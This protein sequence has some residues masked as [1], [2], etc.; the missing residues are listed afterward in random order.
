MWTTA[1]A[2]ELPCPQRAEV[3]NRLVDTL[4]LQVGL[5]IL[6][7]VD[8]L[9]IGWLINNS[10]DGPNEMM[11]HIL[12]DDSRPTFLTNAYQT[13]VRVGVHL[14]A[15]DYKHFSDS[16]WNRRKPIFAIEKVFSSI[17]NNFVDLRLKS[18][19]IWS[20]IEKESDFSMPQRG[21]L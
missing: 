5:S 1:D 7:M 9:S 4:G 21:N 6:N 8:Q 3:H 2:I 14:L 19:N 20:E 17:R 16:V 11:I 13:R 18:R 10:L 15:L 12:V